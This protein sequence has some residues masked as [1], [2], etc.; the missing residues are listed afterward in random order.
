MDKFSCFEKIILRV[1]VRYFINLQ[2]CIN[3]ITVLKRFPGENSQQKKV[4]KFS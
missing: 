1:F 2:N 4:L 3:L